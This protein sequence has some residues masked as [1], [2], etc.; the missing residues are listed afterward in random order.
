MEEQEFLRDK[1]DILKR[2]GEQLGKK[3]Y[4]GEVVKRN[5][6]FIKLEESVPFWRNEI[7]NLRIEV[8]QIFTLVEKQKG[9][10]LKIQP[11]I[12]LHLPDLSVIRFSPHKEN[13][14][15]ISRIQSTQIGSGNGTKLMEIFFCMVRGTLGHIPEIWLECTGSLGHNHTETNHGL[16]E[17]TKFFRKF[18]FRVNDRKQYPRWV[19]MIRPAD[20]SSTS[21]SDISRT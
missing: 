16:S 3:V 5:D 21:T 13:A 14:L 20:I 17:Q 15:E 11:Y 1:K 8:S 19:D 6:H 2:V 12:S 7:P 10:Y 18:G 9:Y 4:D